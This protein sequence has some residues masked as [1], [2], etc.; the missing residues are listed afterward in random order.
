[1]TDHSRFRAP[2]FVRNPH[3][4]TV[5]GKFVS[6]ES[7]LETMRREVWQTP[8]DDEVI[9]VRMHPDKRDVPR[10]VLFHGLEGTERSHYVSPLF[11]AAD[12]R[13]WA[14]ELLLW[15][16]C[17]GRNNRAAR[18]YHSGETADA[19]WFLSTLAA[20]YPDAPLLACGVSLG[21]NVLT[22]M[23]GETNEPLPSALRAAVGVSV[24]FD[25][26]RGSRFINR[27]ASRLYEKWFLRTLRVKA[28]DKAQQYPTLFPAPSRIAA[29][30]TLWEFDDLITGP[31]HGF[32]DAADY[33][34][35]AS[36]LQYLPA[37]QR[38]LLLV[39]ADDD[40]FLPRDVLREV[41]ALAARNPLVELDFSSHGGHV[42]F[43]HGASP[44]RSRSYLTERIPEFL[45]SFV[46]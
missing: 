18:F 3:V 12:A 32:V 10:L 6:R 23:L 28:L 34:A 29:I 11:R 42:G 4:Q 25:L 5:W 41:R 14:A 33:Y 45:G 7:P 21:G 39:S 30:R 19:R 24:P 20:R 46:T 1:M 9:V 35:R 38:P 26:A 36:S 22:K 27:G 8:D 17:G 44:R 43:V 31:L 40:P 15:R 2:W 16:S 13:G 37:V